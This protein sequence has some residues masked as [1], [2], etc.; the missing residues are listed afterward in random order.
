MKNA[1]LILVLLCG[2]LYA[3]ETS[4]A[5]KG[6]FALQ[7]GT[8]TSYGGIGI[9]AEYQFLIKEKYRITPYLGAGISLG[10]TDTSKADYYWNNYAAGCSFEYGNIHRI[11]A[12]PQFLFS[13]NISNKPVDAPIDKKTLFG[14]AFI[15]GYKGTSSFGLIWQLTVGTA[16]IQDP[17]EQ[18]SDYSFEPNLGVGIGYKF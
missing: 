9:L 16:Y 2:N 10:G 4:K 18:N 13:T 15:V 8:G 6:G 5:T 12:G 1:L 17:L 7:A 14:P 3:Q 11:I